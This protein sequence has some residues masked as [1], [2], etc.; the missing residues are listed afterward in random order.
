MLKREGKLEGHKLIVAGEYYSGKERYAEQIDA[1][2]IRGDLVL[3]DRYISDGDVAKLF[4][5]ADLVVQPYRHATQSGVTQ[6]A[7]QFCVPMVV[8]DVGG[9]SEIVPDGRVG[10]VCE[11]TVQGVADA[12]ARMYDGDTIERFRLNCIEERKRLLVGGDVHAHR[13]VVRNGTLIPDRVAGIFPEPL[14]PEN[15]KGLPCIARQPFRFIYSS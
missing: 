5:A 2:G 8:T 14:P 15:Y 10:Y 7:Y 9:L 1:L 12:I 13:R 6:I 3:M 11:P 4:S